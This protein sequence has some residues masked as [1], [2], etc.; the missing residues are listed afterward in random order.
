MGGSHIWGYPQNAWFI[1]EHPI[2]KWMITRELPLWLRK[3]PCQ[4]AYFPF[5]RCQHDD[6]FQFFWI[7]FILL[8]NN[9]LWS[10]FGILNLDSYSITKILWKTPLEATTKSCRLSD[11][12]KLSHGL[13][14]SD[15][16]VLRKKPVAGHCRVQMFKCSLHFP[17]LKLPNLTGS[18]LDAVRTCDGC[19]GFVSSS[20]GKTGRAIGFH[21][22]QLEN[23]P[24]LLGHPT[25]VQ[26]IKP[27][28]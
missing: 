27:F 15:S 28:R 22:L 20:G 3:P 14:A 18:G 4:N 21:R 11:P 12:Q 1:V 23:H 26:I 9:V 7:F 19:H 6:R 24:F 10:R 17:F 25:L 13:I 8:L 5:P 16:M 2:Y